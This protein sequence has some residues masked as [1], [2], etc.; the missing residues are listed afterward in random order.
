MCM[1]STKDEKHN[2]TR[3]F[4]YSI[5]HI[6][7]VVVY[8]SYIVRYT[9]KIFRIFEVFMRVTICRYKLLSSSTDLFL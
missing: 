1:N 4:I 7:D 5:R 9:K 2:S 8:L 6:I 3:T